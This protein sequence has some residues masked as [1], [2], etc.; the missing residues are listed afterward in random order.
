MFSDDDDR[1]LREDFG[2]LWLAGRVLALC[3]VAYVVSLCQ[4]IAR[5]LRG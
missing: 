5:R 3:S 1:E 4:R 2:G